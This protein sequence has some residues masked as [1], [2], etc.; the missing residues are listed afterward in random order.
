MEHSLQRIE[1]ISGS[2]AYPIS[3]SQH[4]RRKWKTRFSICLMKVEAL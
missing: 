2:G 4:S 1:S 3:T